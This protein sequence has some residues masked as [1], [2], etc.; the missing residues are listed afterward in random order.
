MGKQDQ[1]GGPGTAVS[2]RKREDSAVSEDVAGWSDSGQETRPDRRGE[3]PRRVRPDSGPGLRIYKPGQGFYTRIGTAIGGGILAV[4]GTVFVYNQLGVMLDPNAGYYLPAQY[5]VATAFLLA[6][7]VV[8]YWLTGINRKT[9]EF[10]IQ[11]EGE[12]KK[13]NWSTRKEIVKSTKVVILAVILLSVLLF[14]FDVA[15]MLFFGAIKVLRVSPQMLE[16]L[17][18][19]GA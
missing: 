16:G 15:F 9:N 2:E 1:A 5:G 6:M 8:V 17:F 19:G 3:Q 10:F 12:M 4:A 18:G 14:V 11:T 13:V 7:A